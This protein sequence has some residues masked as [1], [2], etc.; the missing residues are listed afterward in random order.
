MTGRGLGFYVFV[1]EVLILN[2]EFDGEFNLDLWKHEITMVR[3]RNL[4]FTPW[5]C[6]WKAAVCVC[7]NDIQTTSSQNV[8]IWNVSDAYLKHGWFVR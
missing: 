1:D 7:V 2:E 3:G 5:Y 6:V 8:L 4:E